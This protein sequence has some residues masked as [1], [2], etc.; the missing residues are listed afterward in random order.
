MWALNI[1][2]E[3]R[4]VFWRSYIKK[5]KAGYSTDIFKK[6]RHCDL[7][8]FKESNNEIQVVHQPVLFVICGKTQALCIP[9]LYLQMLN[10]KHAMVRVGGGWETFG[11]YLLK[12]DPCRMTT[13]TRPGIKSPVKRELS[14]DSY[15]VVGTH[16]R[17][18]K[19]H[20]KPFRQ[21]C[22]KSNSF[23]SKSFFLGGKQP[24]WLD[25]FLSFNLPFAL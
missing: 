13:I 2:W 10:D 14:R 20:F 16:S 19:W 8:C 24:R 3:R 22:L 1:L 7:L 4:G 9:S 21:M 12:H 25:L 15:L 17:L 6:C 5:H 11:T 18:K 23:K